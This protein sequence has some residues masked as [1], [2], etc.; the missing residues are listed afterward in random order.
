MKREFQINLGRDIS[1]IGTYAVDEVGPFW[2]HICTQKGGPLPD[3]L[4]ALEDRRSQIVL[5]IGQLGDFRRGSIH[6]S[7]RRCG[8]PGCACTR[9]DHPGHGPA[10]GSPSSA[11]ARPSR[12]RSPIPPSCA[13]PS[14]RWP[15]S[16]ASSSS[17]PN[18]WRSM[19]ASAS[20]THP[21]RRTWSNGPPW[22][23]TLRAIQNAGQ[24]EV[25]SLLGV[26]VTARRKLGASD[27]RSCGTGDSHGSAQGR[28]AAA[29]RAAGGNPPRNLAAVPPSH[30]P[31][32]AQS[33]VSP[34]VLFGWDAKCHPDSRKPCPR[35]R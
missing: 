9:D 14:A 12:R 29:G 5:A 15:P 30:L 11:A 3:S 35:R 21:R 1:V 7:F 2:V 13:R 24:A 10:C 19:S 18:S 8:K 34:H 31:R 17:A 26:I 33:C 16:A 32:F 6:A 23:G 22:G 25:A 4:S 28:G 27:T 20:C